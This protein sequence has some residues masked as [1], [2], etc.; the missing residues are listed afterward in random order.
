MGNRYSEAMDAEEVEKNAYFNPVRKKEK[1]V[2]S[3]HK[4][5]I[6][7]KLPVGGDTDG[8]RGNN[9]RALEKKRVFENPTTG[10]GSAKLRMNK[11]VWEGLLY[12]GISKA[13]LAK[14][15]GVSRSTIYNHIRYGKMY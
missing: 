4:I 3:R 1:M 7:D 12:G 11:K 10:G 6:E 2:R 13:E 9:K 15:L 5:Q 14:D 8:I